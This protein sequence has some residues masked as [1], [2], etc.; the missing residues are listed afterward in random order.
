MGAYA[1][2]PVTDDSA[3][4]A[5][6]AL[7]DEDTFVIPAAWRR[8]IAFRRGGVPGPALPTGQQAIDAAIDLLSDLCTGIDALFGYPASDPELV[9]AGRAY[10]TGDRNCLG[11]AVVAAAVDHELGQNNPKRA[12]VLADAWVADAGVAFAVQ[13]AIELVRVAAERHCGVRR[14]TVGNLY[15]LTYRTG[16]SAILGRVRAHLAVAADQQH[17]SAVNVLRGYREQGHTQRVISCYLLPDQTDWVAEECQ[18]MHGPGND[19]AFDLLFQSINSFEQL[20]QITNRMN[21]WFIT[22]QPGP[23]YSVAEGVGPAIAPKLVRWFDHEQTSAE[24][25]RQLL[26]V[27]SAL[28][29]D[30]AMRL[31]L[32]RLDRRHVQPAV[33]SMVKRFPVRGV[34][35]LAE[36]AGGRNTAARQA[37]NLLRIHVLSNPA[38]V[39]AASPALDDAAGQR[40]ETLLAGENSALPEAGPDVLPAVLVSP[41]WTVR[42]RRVK[43]IVID[44]LSVSLDRAMDWRSGEREEWATTRG[45]YMSWWRPGEDLTDLAP[46]VAAGMLNDS[47][48]IA[49]FTRAPE[50]VARPLVGQWRPTDSWE[51][52]EWLRQVAGRFELDALPPAVHLARHSPGEA[53]EVLLPYACTEVAELMA[54][55]LTRLKSVRRTASAWLGRHPRVAA[56]ALVPVALGKSSGRGA[57]EQALRVAATEHRDAVVEAARGYGE[58]AEA[59]IVA[60]LDTDPLEELP[61]KIPGLPAW[62]EPALLPPVLLR[63]RSAVLPPESTRHVCT[64]LAISRPEKVYAGLEVVKQACDRA[65]LAE[66]GWALFE[67]WRAAGTPHRDGWT[68]SALG[69]IGDDETARRLT[70]LIRTWPGES[71]HAR[72]V[73]GLDVLAALGSDV[74]LT[75][76]YGISQKVKFKGLKDRARQKVA[77]VAE[78][79]GLSAEQLGDRLVP[80]LGLDAAGSMVLDYGPRRFTVG[81]DEQLKPYVI[82]DKGTRRKELPKP[83]ARDDQNL[84]PEAYRRFAGLKKDVRTLAADQ[85][86]RF[87]AAMVA[88]RRWPVAEFRRY[89]LEHPLLWHLVRR[90]VW[91]TFDT[92]GGADTAFRVAEDRSLADVDDDV[93]ILPENATIGLA[94]PLHLGA[95]LPAWSEVF[96]DYEVLQPFAQLGRQV[97][98]LTEAERDAKL[99]T[100]FTGAKTATTALLGL[101]RHGWRR[102]EPQD[103]GIQCW[104]ERE[105]PSGRAAVIDLDPGIV[106]GMVN[107]WPEQ[108]IEQ[109]WINDRP[110]GDWHRRGVVRFGDLDPVT[111][112]ELLRDL[113]EVTA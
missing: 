111:V 37:A 73:A 97:Y 91:V 39:A 42:R 101:E 65:S 18:R 53:G 90:L 102:G 26:T 59:G 56:R 106:V 79:L 6:A 61:S 108:K 112:S 92:N 113:T 103:A 20:D 33:L 15:T 98:E 14:E 80:D 2:K 72:A 51:A 12:G 109:V 67:L 11:A 23:L 29:T 50:A 62:L 44:D 49:F 7:P 64:M 52:G 25:K 35:L 17:A 89:F 21:P 105:L 31:L 19:A 104:L 63:D 99:L 3:A 43:P 83:G 57:A 30:E 8:S 74:A 36:A 55:W 16:R 27:L 68:L 110:H 40:I 82:D 41:P 10:L 84:A 60:L 70:P 47:E 22:D 85:I 1:E 96:A 4:T 48:L 5:A 13:A 78:K 38:A 88:G 46:Q 100:R 24:G 94:H 107:E 76:L 93:F 81:F 66:F 71:Q 87:E 95:A 45:G 32:E 69:W 54:D 86:R 75:H 28:P 77:E 58:A 9:A 34:R